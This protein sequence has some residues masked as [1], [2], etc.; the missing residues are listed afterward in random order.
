MSTDD[1]FVIAM[2]SGSVQ[3]GS[4]V[5][6]FSHDNKKVAYGTVVDTCPGCTGDRAIDLSPALFQQFASTDDGVFNVCW[7]F[8]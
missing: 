1:E 8:A 5:K 4:R 7:A 2:P 6:V 3:C